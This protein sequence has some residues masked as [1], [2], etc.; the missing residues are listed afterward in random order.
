[1]LLTQLY[2][3]RLKPVVHREIFILKDLLYYVLNKLEI[4]YD[5]NRG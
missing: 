1:M 3:K 4:L 5:M 2:A